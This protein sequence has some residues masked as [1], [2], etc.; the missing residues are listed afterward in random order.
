MRPAII[1]LIQLAQKT[2]LNFSQCSQSILWTQIKSGTYHISRITYI[3]QHLCDIPDTASDYLMH[4]FLRYPFNIINTPPSSTL[5]PPPYPHPPHSMGH[6][7]QNP[8]FLYPIPRTLPH[9]TNRQNPVCATSGYLP[10]ETA[11]NQSA[12]S[13]SKTTAPQN[14]NISGIWN[15]YDKL[16]IR[17]YQES[18]SFTVQIGNW[19]GNKSMHS[20]LKPLS[21]FAWRNCMWWRHG[22][23]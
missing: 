10:Q 1:V 14:I 16:W 2:G 5:Y 4:W 12:Q 6:N 15:F 13:S 11:D 23:G 17:N 22:H 20:S 18:A 19:I 7:P 21:L 9:L 3:W 8:S